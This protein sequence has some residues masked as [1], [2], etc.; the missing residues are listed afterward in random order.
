MTTD[1]KYII[2]HMKRVPGSAKLSLVTLSPFDGPGLQV[3]TGIADIVLPS[4]MFSS[5]IPLECGI[6]CIINLQTHI[7]TGTS[8]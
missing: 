7:K 5:D 4:F 2:T 3:R 1:G 8:P 6:N